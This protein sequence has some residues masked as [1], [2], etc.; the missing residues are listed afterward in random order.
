MSQSHAHTQEGLTYFLLG[1]PPRWGQEELLG[2]DEEEQVREKEGNCHQVL[3]Q[4][5][6]Q[7]QP[8]GLFQVDNV[9]LC[10]HFTPRPDF[11]T[12]YVEEPDSAGHKS[13]PVS[14][15]VSLFD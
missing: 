5:I 1:E 13:G 6:S 4:Y 12:I 11:Y 7:I 8:A 9:F 10:F 3:N 14:A 15:Q 2:L